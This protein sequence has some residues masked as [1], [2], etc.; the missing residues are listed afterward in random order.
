MPVPLAKYLLQQLLLAPARVLDP[1]AG[2]GSTLVAARTLGH[3]ASG[4]DI[5][6]LAVMMARGYTASYDSGAVDRLGRRVLK[7]AEK[8]RAALPRSSVRKLLGAAEEERD[9]IKYWFPRDT[10]RELFALR[11]TIRQERDVSLRNLGWLVFSSLIISKGASVSYAI[12]IARSRPHKDEERDLASPFD[13]WQKRFGAI[14]RRLPFI[15]EGGGH[16]P[17]ISRGDARKMDVASN[18]IDAVLTS[19]PYL[20][21]VDYLRGHKFSLLWMGHSLADLRDIR[22]TMIGSERGL[23]KPDGLPASMED[24][25]VASSDEERIRALSRRYLSDLRYSL[26]EMRRVVRPQG[27]IALVL[28]PSILDRDEPDSVD[29]ARALAEDIDLDFVG[30]TFRPLRSDRRS[31]PPPQWVSSKSALASRMSQEA[32]VV[33]RKRS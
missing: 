7:K 11:Q 17:I 22:G 1:M 19:P 29:V 8:I 27:L 32:I 15:D 28:G 9:F 24:C 6:P 18:S 3:R 20:N 21:A 12:D 23:W 31:L 16:E 4:I 5:D 33:L 14:T 25:L 10:Q 26:L 30:G 13:M 2:S